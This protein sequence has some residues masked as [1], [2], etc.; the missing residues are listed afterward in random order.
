MI[1]R[2]IPCVVPF[3]TSLAISRKYSMKG[4]SEGRGPLKG[5]GPKAKLRQERVSS[6]YDWIL[7]G[8]SVRDPQSISRWNKLSGVFLYREAEV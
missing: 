3:T 8:S 1:D 6:L 4:L 5:I 2:Y 7:T